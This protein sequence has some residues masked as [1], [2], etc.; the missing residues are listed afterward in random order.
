MFAQ[1]YGMNYNISELFL[2][3]ERLVVRIKSYVS[4]DFIYEDF[5]EQ[6]SKK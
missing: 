2:E 3:A 5:R 4:E 6:I 1:I